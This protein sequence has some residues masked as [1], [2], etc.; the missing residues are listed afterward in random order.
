MRR[1]AKD[2][3]PQNRLIDTIVLAQPSKGNTME[4][5]RDLFPQMEQLDRR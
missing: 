3:S 2:M 1:E 5:R 4:E